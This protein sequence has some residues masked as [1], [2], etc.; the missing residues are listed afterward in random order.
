VSFDRGAFAER[1]KTLAAKGVFLGTSSWKYSGWLDQI[2]DR[3][4]YDHRGR[5]N[6]SGFERSCLSEY[7]EVFKTVGVDW[8]YY[9]WPLKPNVA[10]MVS[11]VPSDFRFGFKVTEFVTTK[12]FSQQRRY[13]RQAGKANEGFLDAEV[14]S[15]RFLGELEP[16]RSQVGVLMFE[17]SKFY[18]ADYEHG[19]DF[20]ADLDK[21]LGK[22]PKGWPYGVEIRNDHFLKP[23]YFA[24]LAKHGVAHVFNSWAQMPSVGHQMLIEGSLTQ[25][26]LSATRF[27]LR[28]GRKYQEAVDSFQPYDRIQD[29]FPEA[30]LDGAK[31]ISDGSAAPGRR[32][33]IFVNNRLEGNAPLTIDAMMDAA[34]I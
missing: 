3:A 18:K 15:R 9:T 4:R 12:K 27:L 22:L 1:L 14:F 33:F 21:F 26:G 34:G 11:A 20:V 8:S 10:Q 6:E 23:E 24:T 2:Y 7:G 25:P 30:R 28:P 32:T 13:G 29:P 31:L 5:F 17:F 19:E 16:F